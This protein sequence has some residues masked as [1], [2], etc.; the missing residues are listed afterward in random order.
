MTSKNEEATMNSIIVGFLQVT[1]YS[2][3][4]WT[5][6]FDTREAREELTS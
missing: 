2:A 5:W 3:A 4:I 1:T 6:L